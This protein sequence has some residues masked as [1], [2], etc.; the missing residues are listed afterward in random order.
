MKDISNPL[1]INIITCYFIIALLTHDSFSYS[2]WML[3]FKLF[4]TESAMLITVI[5]HYIVSVQGIKLGAFAEAGTGT[6]P[7]WMAIIHE[8]HSFEGSIL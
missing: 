2:V 1:T 8:M 6:V 3:L 4:W 5:F 7:G